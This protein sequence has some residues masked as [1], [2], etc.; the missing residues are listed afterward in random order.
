M[1]KRQTEMQNTSLETKQIWSQRCRVCGWIGS[2]S[3]EDD[4]KAQC[5]AC[6]GDGGK[7]WGAL[8]GKGMIDG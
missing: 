5:P 6:G 2:V 4:I 7:S 1:D 8:S 3:R